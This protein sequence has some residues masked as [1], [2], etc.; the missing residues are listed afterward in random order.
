MINYFFRNEIRIK[1]YHII[2]FL[3]ENDMRSN[4]SYGNFFK[5]KLGTQD[6]NYLIYYQ[7]FVFFDQTR[8]SLFC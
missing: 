1:L 6:D 8:Y 2:S 4:I 7:F 3:K 5:K